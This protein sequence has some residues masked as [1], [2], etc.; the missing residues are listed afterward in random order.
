LVF[1]VTIAFSILHFHISTKGVTM[2]YFSMFKRVICVATIASVTSNSAQFLD[3]NH[4]GHKSKVEILKMLSTEKY[5]PYQDIIVNDV[6][7]SKG[8]GPD[9]SSRYEMIREILARYDHPIKV[10]DIGANNGYFSI[11][12]A[13][14]FQALCVMVDQSDRLCSICKL[15]DKC[16]N[17]IYLKKT[18]SLENLQSLEKQ[19]HFDV[20]LMLNVIHHMEPWKEILDVIFE[21]GDTVIIETPPAN[22]ERVTKKPCIPLI[23]DYLLRKQGGVI[24]GETP[25]SPANAFDFLESLEET[26][27]ALQKKKFTPNAFAKMFCFK[28]QNQQHGSPSFKVSV[29]HELNGIFPSSDSLQGKKEIVIQ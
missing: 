2:S 4:L 23:E 25:R 29:F 12:I 9:C 16:P 11:R 5:F 18:L 6:V 28:N 7:L 1:E 3:V 19:E 10:L 8:L 17:L 15:N 24:L 21:L 13:N 14:D 20:V 22:D 26:T 27:D